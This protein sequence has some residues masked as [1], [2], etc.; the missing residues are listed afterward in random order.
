MASGFWPRLPTVLGAADARAFLKRTFVYSVN[1][2][3]P[4][5]RSIRRCLMNWAAPMRPRLPAQES[6]SK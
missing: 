2:T 4:G 5:L 1:S 3:A 6:R